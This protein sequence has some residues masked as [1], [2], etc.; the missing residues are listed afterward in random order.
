M[1]QHLGAGEMQTLQ[2]VV[3]GPTSPTQWERF[4]KDMVAFLK[5][6][7]GIHAK[8]VSIR[9]HPK[10]PRAGA[11]AKRRKKRGGR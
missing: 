3:Y 6:H 9:Y 11:T 10:P 2:M 4:K 1:A 8:V 5:K 7:R